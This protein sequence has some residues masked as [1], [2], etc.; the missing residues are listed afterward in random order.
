MGRYYMQRKPLY[1]LFLFCILVVLASC[2]NNGLPA[3]NGQNIPQG[4]GMTPEPG[5]DGK[6]Q[7][8]PDGH[9][10][11][12][13]TSNGVDYV[14]SDNGRLYALNGTDG[15]VR[16]Q[17][18]A[19]EPVSIARVV[20]GVIYAHA[21]ADTTAVAFALNAATGRLL[22]RYPLNNYISTQLVDGGVVL[23]GTA[24]NST[25]NTA[26]LLALQASNGTLLWT[27]TAHAS[28][29]GLLNA[30]NSVVY[31]AEIQGIGPDFSEY[32]T[33][34][35]ESD[36]H[37]LWQLPIARGDGYA[38]GVSS[39]VAGVVYV[40]TN[41]ASVYAVRVNDGKVLWHVGRPASPPG[42]AVPVPSAPVYWN[43]AVYAVGKDMQLESQSLYAL[44]ASDGKQLWSKQLGA[45]PGPLLNIPVL[46]NGVI[47]IDGNVNGV[48][49]LRTSDGGTI[50]QQNSINVFGDVLLADGHVIV[51]TPQGIITLN[52]SDGSVLWKR[53]I[54]HHDVE[55]TNA[56]PDIVGDGMVYASTTTGVV[57]A[58]SE[59]DGH[60][61]WRYTI[62][63]L[64]VPQTL[65]YAAS[66]HFADSVS[67][68]QAIRIITDLGLQ[69]VAECTVQWV[70]QGGKS[71][72]SSPNWLT[73]SA[74]V[75]S[76]PLW[77][78][79]L[80]TTPGVIETQ[81]MGPHSCP[82]MRYDPNKPAY[83]GPDA[84]VTYLRVTFQDATSYDSA[85][86][87]VN[88]LGLR[89]ANPCY[90]QA[91]AQG[92]KPTW[93]TIG[94]EQSFSQAHALILATSFNSAVIWQQQLQSLSGVKSVDAPYQ[95][96]C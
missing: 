64:A 82:N 10:E 26:Q 20:N 31:Y 96:A 50:W 94:Q 68:T 13:V 72:Y 57:E 17:Y 89:L 15:R 48:L 11:S 67:Y 81:V 18:K 75:A 84:P 62:Q 93:N 78:E 40:G 71:Y 39:E 60:V 14:G 52:S 88:D 61:L 4:T 34:L 74:T 42:D 3:T 83:L 36:G 7:P 2:G 53:D 80:Q 77:L 86:D 59:S 92:K 21:N 9:W 6:P 45:N 16:W 49:A 73:V 25:T 30:G 27:Y 65:A 56:V 22:W 44:R 76:A 1:C 33:A 87:A 51:N 54:D 46:S 35:R 23:L 29:P 12:M 66:I 43:G 85:V 95:A 63:E 79:R 37:G 28:T 8:L 90:E 58:I 5:N 32:I 91:R 55:M 24:S 47:Y 38:Y 69:T 70:P 19:G 41:H